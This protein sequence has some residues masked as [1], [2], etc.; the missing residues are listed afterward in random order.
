MS[1]IGAWGVGRGDECGRESIWGGGKGV[2]SG[3]DENRVWNQGRDGEER[4]GTITE[5]FGTTQNYDNAYLE[6]Q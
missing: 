4:R 3:G 1:V 2:R 6:P 5:N